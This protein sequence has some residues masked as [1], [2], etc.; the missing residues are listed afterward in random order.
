[1]TP[2]TLRSPEEVQ[3]VV[4]AAHDANVPVVPR[5]VSNQP[6]RGQCVPLIGHVMC[7]HTHRQAGSGLEGGA[8]PYQ[9]GVA[10][11]LTKMKAFE[12]FEEEMQARVGP[13]M[14]KTELDERFVQMI[15]GRVMIASTIT[16]T[17]TMTTITI[18]MTTISTI[19]IISTT[20]TIILV[21]I[22]VDTIIIKPN[23]AIATT[24][25]SITN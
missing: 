24:P 18:T 1:M 6:S 25:T 3:A 17:I 21:M 12:L 22:T 13:G 20:I 14:R 16:I 11:D 4:K 19:T 15:C 9:G 8:I 23:T 7:M 5:G 2:F 10:L